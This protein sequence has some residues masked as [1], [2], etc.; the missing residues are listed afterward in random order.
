MLKSFLSS[1]VFLFLTVTTTLFVVIFSCVP[2]TPG[3]NAKELVIQ[4]SKHGHLTNAHLVYARDG[5]N[6]TWVKLTGTNGIYKFT[7]NNPQG[8]YSVA[9]AEPEFGYNPKKVWF[10]NTKLSETNF[11]PIDVFNATD[12]DAATLTI[13]VPIAYDGKQL[14][15]FFHHEHR[16]PFVGENEPTAEGLKRA[17]AP[18][19]PK[20]KADLVIFIGAPWSELGVEKVAIFRDFVLNTDK[21]IT[22][23]EEMLKTPESATKF[24][25]IS[26]EWLVGGTTYTFGSDIKIPSALKSDNDLYILGFTDW[27][28]G[29]VYSEYRK[30]YPTTTP[31]ATSS[32]N[33]A[34]LPETRVSTSVEANNLKIA[35]TPYNLNL[36][37]LE[38]IL[39]TVTFGYYDSVSSSGNPEFDVVYIA[40]V[41]SGYLSAVGNNYVVPKIGG[42]F[43]QFDIDTTKSILVDPPFYTASNKSIKD[44]FIPTDGTKILNFGYWVF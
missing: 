22:L 13:N 12:E 42:D 37:G 34:N 30:D 21:E 40:Y 1:K 9:V 29:F 27:N 25:D 32:I 5:L 23:T 26:V 43:A 31:F 8:L 17:I 33:P 24:D 6:G 36:T 28:R 35:I 38:T 39:Y 11:L 7:V 10:F 20:A 44:L 2:V 3:E 15:V 19:L 4:T 14:S 18:G 41:S 16:F